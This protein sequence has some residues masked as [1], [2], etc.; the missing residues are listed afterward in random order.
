MIDEERIRQLHRHAIAEA[1]RLLAVALAELERWDL[2][3]G[4]PADPAVA[5]TATRELSTI[6]RQFTRAQ[7]SLVHRGDD[8]YR[9]ARAVLGYCDEADG[10]G[11]MPPVQLG[12]A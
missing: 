7:A 3:R 8:R 6:A 12:A 9:A 10:R 2:V 1:D 4:A 5:F 11:D